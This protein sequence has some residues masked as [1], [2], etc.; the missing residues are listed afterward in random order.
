[1]FSIR[2]PDT[3]F[4][5]DLFLKAGYALLSASKAAIT[6]GASPTTYSQ[7]TWAVNHEKIITDT[8]FADYV[9]LKTEK[10]D[11]DHLN[12]FFGKARTVAERNQPFASKL[13]TKFYP[14]PPVLEY[15]RFVKTDEFPQNTYNSTSATTVSAARFF[16]R[17]RLIPT[18]NASSVIRIDQYLSEIPWPSG[19]LKH[20]QPIPTEINGQYLGMRVDLP[21]CL[22][23]LVVL[24]EM[25]PEAILVENQGTINVPQTSQ[26]NR[27]IFPATNFLNWAPFVIED[28]VEEVN[29]LYLR[30]KITIHPPYRPEP[31]DF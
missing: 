31:Q 22:H 4:R 5:P 23:P 16:Q 9:Y 14:W 29:G 15:L 30:R 3:K 21:K 8:E 24:N 6:Q 25:V 18:P 2:V 11:A 26:T 20:P 17:R 12:F 7:F 1:M 10:A 13:S 19:A 28:D 27:Q